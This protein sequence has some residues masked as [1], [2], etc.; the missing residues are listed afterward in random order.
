MQGKQGETTKKLADGA[1]EMYKFS[2]NQMSISDFGMPLGMALNHDNRW[3]K[4]AATIPWDEIELRYAAL[5][6]N[7]KGNVAKPLRMALGALLIQTEYQYPDVEVPLQIQ[8]TPCLQYFCG[9]PEYQDKPPFDPS[10]MV[11]FRKR[12]TPE[13]LGEINE[14]IIAKAEK[15]P[16]ESQTNSH[17]DPDSPPPNSGTLIVDSTCAPQSIRYPQDTSLLNEARENLE[18]MVDTMYDP[19]DGTKPRTYRQKARRDYLNIAKRKNKT[20]KMIRKAVGKQ[21]RY[22][23]RDLQFVDTMLARGKELSTWQRERL[24]TIK[25]LY[26]QQLHMFQNQ[27]HQ[28]ENRIVSLGQPWIRPIVRGKAKEK[29]EFGAKLDV[30]VSGGFVRLE[31]T[32]FDAYNESANLQDVI[33]RYRART[34]HYPELVLADQIY[35]NRENLQYC[36]QNGIR[37]S[38]KPLGRPKREPDIDKRQER[39]EQIERIEV[40]RKIGLAKGSYG[41]SLIRARLKGT[42]LT[43][44][45]LSI[46][47]MNITHITRA[48]C[49]L[50]F[51][52]PFLR[53]KQFRIR[54][55]VFIQ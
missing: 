40:E 4:K 28:V 19:A 15:K 16:E 37:I 21:L 25:T 3:V 12:L 46:L 44:I 29:C 17:D 2:S 55:L 11:Y 30:S 53:Q 26:A 49:A 52:W 50:F 20:A 6:K 1:A 8:E 10:L 35:R 7:R 41:L 18:Q 32:S 31:H 38:G 39:R 48:F 33:E 13:I 47:A 14:M 24:E 54:K 5:F 27:T 51:W 9:L 45:A 34:G 43:A 22:I 36:K 23:R 42:T